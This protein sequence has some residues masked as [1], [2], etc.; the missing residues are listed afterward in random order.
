MQLKKSRINY[1][2]WISGSFHPLFEGA[3]QLSLA[4]LCAIGFWTYLEL[5]VYAPHI[6]RRISTPGTLCSIKLLYILRGCHPVSRRIPAN[7]VC[8]VA[9]EHCI[10]SP[11]ARIQFALFPFRSP[12]LRESQLISSPPGTKMFYFPGFPITMP[13][14]SDSAPS[15]SHHGFRHGEVYGRVRLTRPFRS[16]P[17]PSSA[18]RT[19]SSIQ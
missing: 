18:S 2:Y 4:L 16:L 1:R 3:F 12:L 6:P 8:K 19:E 13:K 17:R 14:H 11:L 7:F 15:G 5:E 9:L 10:T